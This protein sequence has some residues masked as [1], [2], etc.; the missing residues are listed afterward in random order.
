MNPSHPNIARAF[1]PT[2]LAGLT[3]RNRFV[4]TATFEG[5]TPAG[6][7]GSALAQFHR[8]VA[9]GGTALTTVAYCGVSPDARTFDDQMHVHAAILPA[10]RAL[11]DGVHAEGG[12]VSGQLAHCGG[13]SR[14]K[15]VLQRRPLGPSAGINEYGLLAGV[16]FK[17]AMTPTDMARTAADYART[18]SALR[19]AGFD[20]FEIH[21]GHG[22]L[23]SQFI[24]PLSNRR[25]D[26]YG[27]SLENRM[28]FPLQVLAAVREAVG[29]EV[30]LLAKLNLSDGLDGGLDTDGAV[31]CA[32]LLEAAGIDAI[33]MSGGLVTR[34]PMYLFR[35]ASPLPGLIATERNP[36]MRLGMKASGKSAFPSMPFEPLYF[37]EQALRVREAVRVPLAY[38]G[39]VTSGADVEQL[40]AD[41]FDLVCLGRAL[42]ND[43]AMSERLRSD[44]GWRSPCTHCNECLPTMSTPAGTHCVLHETEQAA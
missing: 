28:R 18:A 36:L 12:L 40:M 17:G 34:T 42:L 21:M 9:A 37:R 26:A 4:K 25:T 19:G 29:D 27:G 7:P 13:F 16:P 43:P 32:R 23:L 39:G 30:P 38:L 2:R 41:G 6:V 20:A 24:S 31:Q 35:G 22:Y 3:L 44:P 5:R 8:E 1:E 11:A 14:A 15:P 33:V 10:L